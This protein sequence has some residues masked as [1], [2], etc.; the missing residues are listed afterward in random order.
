MSERDYKGGAGAVARGILPPPYTK[1]TAAK[2]TVF[3]AFRS[4]DFA[5]DS[6]ASLQNDRAPLRMTR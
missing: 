4:F 6:I 3:N 5:L 1:K 2:A